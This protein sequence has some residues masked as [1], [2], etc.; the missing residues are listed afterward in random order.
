MR[1]DKHWTT[2]CIWMQEQRIVYYDPKKW[3]TAK[4]KKKFRDHGQF[5]LKRALEWL[6]FE[7]VDKKKKPLSEI[8][9]GEATWQLVDAGDDQPRQSEADGTECGVI[10]ILNCGFLADNVP[11]SDGL[12]DVSCLDYRKILGCDILRRNYVL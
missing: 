9:G 12:F 5:Y 10:C 3:V 6:E 1:D 7:A 2:V 11:L 4:S 8:Y